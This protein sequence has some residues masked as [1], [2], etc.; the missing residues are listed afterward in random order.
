MD[1]DRLCENHT[2][3]VVRC[4]VLPD[5][6]GREVL[7]TIAKL[8]LVVAPDGGVLLGTPPRPVRDQA[9][10]TSGDP[11]ASH[12]YPSDLVDEKPG[13]DV[14]LVGTAQPPADRSATWM[15]VTLRVAAGRRP[16]DK[17][18]RVFGTRVLYRGAWDVAPGPPAALLPTPLVYELTYGGRD[19]QSPGEA[20]LVDWRNPAGTGVARDRARLVGQRAPALEHPE[21]ALGSRKPAPACFGPL[22]P[23]W[24]PR[25]A[26]A[27]TYDEAWSK[28]RAPFRP[29]DFDPLHHACAPPDQR[30]EEPLFADVPVEIIGVTRSGIWRFRLPRY[31]PMFQAKVSGQTR[32]LPTHLD[33][34]LIDADAGV[35]ELVWRTS[36]PLPRKSQDLQ[37][38]RVTDAGPLP[39]GATLAPPATSGAR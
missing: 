19:D 25:S 36:L 15:D 17:T 1:L 2:P 28:T 30:S 29:A 20:P 38:I 26:L 24:L 32:D 6:V 7:T 8:T 5:A 14:L 4:A 27:G 13:T 37:A 10:P 3:M 21:A 31:A 33:T 11:W 9:V 23:S 22:P 34:Y 12:L 35:V 39:P 18:V 16:I